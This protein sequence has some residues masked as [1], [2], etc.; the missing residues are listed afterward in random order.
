MKGRGK[1][2]RTWADLSDADRAIVTGNI[3]ADLEDVTE[4]AGQGDEYPGEW[5]V[6]ARAYRLAI[7]A[8]RLAARKPDGTKT[9]RAT[10]ACKPNRKDT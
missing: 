5:K 8:L 1:V 4:C 7:R 10:G 2:P 3:E 6:R 9:K